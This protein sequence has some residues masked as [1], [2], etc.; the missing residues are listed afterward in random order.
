MRYRR[1][2]VWILT[3][4]GAGLF[5]IFQSPVT[6]VK[7]GGISQAIMLPVISIGALYM[8][9]RRLPK[10]VLPKKWITVA[11]WAACIITGCLML[12]YLGLTLR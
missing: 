12:Y 1:K 7:V 6:M 8:R 11:L 5:L 2:F 3:A 10:E 9:Y 4:I